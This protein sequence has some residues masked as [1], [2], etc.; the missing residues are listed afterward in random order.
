MD[1]K[2]EKT[3]EYPAL[4]KCMIVESRF[5]VRQEI[6]NSIKASALFEKV[7]EAQSLADGIEKVKTIKLDACFVGTSISPNAVEVFLDKASAT[8]KSKNC[9]FIVVVNETNKDAVKQFAKSHGIINWPSNRAN[10]SASIVQSIIKANENSPWKDLLAL[11]KQEEIEALEKRKYDPQVV[12]LIFANCAEDL[13]KISIAI[14]RR[15]YGL[16]K[17]GLPDLRAKKDINNFVDQL[18]AKFENEEEAEKLKEFFQR[19][20]SQWVI[21]QIVLSPQEAKAILEHDWSTFD[22]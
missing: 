18:T 9:S 8:S 16:D 5:L 6:V 15:E 21:N 7:L 13:R 3:I 14:R 4:E 2:E 12:A 19:T 1:S 17:T 10:F 20:L 22:D 11:S